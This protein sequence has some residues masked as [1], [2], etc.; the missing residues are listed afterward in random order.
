MLENFQVK[1]WVKCVPTVHQQ[2]LQQ[3]VES[4]WAAFCQLALCHGMHPFID[5]IMGHSCVVNRYK[6]ILLVAIGDNKVKTPNTLKM[7]RKHEARVW[8]ATS[9]RASY[10]GGISVRV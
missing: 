9:H 8:Q 1:P 3:T 4:L 2:Q 10:L 7:A 5:P 6:V